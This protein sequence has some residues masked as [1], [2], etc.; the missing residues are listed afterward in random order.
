MRKRDYQSS[1]RYMQEV[2]GMLRYRRRVP[3]DLQTIIGRTEWVHSLG[4]SVGQE[5]HA[6]KLIA[7]YNLAYAS[8]I[9]QARVQKVFSGSPFVAIA[10]NPSA[11]QNPQLNTQPTNKVLIS[12]VY[13]YDLKVYGGNRDEKAF[14]VAVDSVV[15]QM[16]DLD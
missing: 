7:D 1:V 9:A 5:A 11:A 6:A 2:D 16:G 10:A 12:E 4:L 14:Q 8:V 15:R 13:A 3:T